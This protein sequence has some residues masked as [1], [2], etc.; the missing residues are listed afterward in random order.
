MFSDAELS[1]IKNTFSGDGEDY[2]YLIRNALLQ[3]P[4]TKE[5][6]IKLKG[7][8]SAPVYAVV[9]KKILPT[10]DPD[11]PFGQLGDLYQSLTADLKTKDIDQMVPLF[12][13]K[14][15]EIDYLTQQFDYLMDV[16]RDFKPLHVLEDM[17]LIETDGNAHSNFVRTTARN[18]I[19][20][21]VD[22]FLIQLKALAGE[23]KETPEEQKKRLTRD[24]S[25]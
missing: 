18:F 10:L 12:W 2:L 24:S 8:M 7:I 1:L 14:K 23:V 25:K 4:L 9:K 11:A 21:Y 17:K 15:L 13:A 20:G 6:K 16:E 22:S 19:L 5:E 3:F